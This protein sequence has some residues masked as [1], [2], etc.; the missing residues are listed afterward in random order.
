M[1]RKNFYLHFEGYVMVVTKIITKM[2]CGGRGIA[3]GFREFEE[4]EQEELWNGNGLVVVVLA[5]QCD[6]WYNGGGGN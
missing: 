4:W 5:A 6:G 3:I 1:K 2:R